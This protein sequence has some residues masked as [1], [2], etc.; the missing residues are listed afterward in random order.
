MVAFWCITLSILAVTCYIKN[1]RGKYSPRDKV[2]EDF[3]FLEPIKKRKDVKDKAQQRQEEYDEL[4][5]K[6][7]DD[8][9]IAVI[10]PTINNGQ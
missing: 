3:G 4:K 9:L 1:Q 6:G 2:Q 10:L 8:E 5:R 7:Y